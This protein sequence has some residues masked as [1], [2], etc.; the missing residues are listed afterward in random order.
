M[1]FRLGFVSNSSSTTYIITFPK[2]MKEEEIREAK[3]KLTKPAVK[4]LFDYFENFYSEEYLQEFLDELTIVSE[5]PKE[6]VYDILIPPFPTYKNF[7]KFVEYMKA[8]YGFD[9]TYLIRGFSSV[10]KNYIVG[11]FS[12]SNEDENP[13][14]QM[15]YFDDFT[16]II[17]HPRLKVSSKYRS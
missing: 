10:F 4:G 7:Y 11:V 14:C 17:L 8:I 3:L 1:K 2:D 15:L 9:D 16:G 13:I 6:I 12:V 5:T